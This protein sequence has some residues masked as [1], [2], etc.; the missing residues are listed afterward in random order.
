MS[1]YCLIKTTIRTNRINNHSVILQQTFQIIKTQKFINHICRNIISVF[2]EH[3]S[4]SFSL[5]FGIY[6][7]YV[8]YNIISICLCNKVFIYRFK[9]IFWNLIFV[10]NISVF[11]T[12][13]IEF[14]IHTFGL[15]ICKLHPFFVYNCSSWR[16]CFF[17][18]IIWNSIFIII[19]WATI[20]IHFH[21][22]RSFR[23][24]IINICNQIAIRIF[25][26]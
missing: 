4:K 9:L 20:R 21:S 1:V 18:N 7:R 22:F 26:I 23:A 10:I 6:W 17:I 25:H 3:N 16:V 24:I 13:S 5:Y 11:S 15:L 8:I 2:S 12:S 19:N 14:A